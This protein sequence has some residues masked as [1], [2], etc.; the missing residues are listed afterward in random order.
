MK[1]WLWIF[2]VLIVL[3]V[4]ILGWGIATNWWSPFNTMD[5][6]EAGRYCYTACVE[7]S[8]DRYCIPDLSVYLDD[9]QIWEGVSCENLAM[10]ERVQ[11][12]IEIECP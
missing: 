2:F 8:R 10:N 12:C 3:V 9:G 11:S 1:K 5:A 7:N 4:G 6:E